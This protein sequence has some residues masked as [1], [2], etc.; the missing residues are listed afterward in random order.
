AAGGRAVHGVLTNRVAVDRP[1]VLRSVQGPQ[2]SVIQGFQVPGAGFGE[3]AIRCAYLANGA[4]LSGFTLANGATRS[5]SYDDRERSGGGV[6]CESANV[7][8]SNCVVTGNAAVNGGGAQGGTLNNCTLG[9][10][11]AGEFGGGAE[12]C[13]LNNCTLSG[14]SA[15]QGGGAYEATLT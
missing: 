1:V 10:N 12:L 7:G 2:F 8:V 6:W 5:A 11:S 15:G 9:G 4:S 13:T 3:G 14:N